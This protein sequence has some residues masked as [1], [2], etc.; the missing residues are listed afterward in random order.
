MLQR[1]EELHQLFSDNLPE[2][3]RPLAPQPPVQPHHR[4]SALQHEALHPV[5][6]LLLGASDPHH[7]PIEPSSPR[8]A[9]AEPAAAAATS[10]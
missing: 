7:V 9:E 4:L 2:D 8:P 1:T 3:Q 10:V 6:S 5:V